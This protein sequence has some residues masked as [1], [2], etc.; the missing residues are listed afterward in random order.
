MHLTFPSRLA[1]IYDFP[2]WL[3]LVMWTVFCKVRFEAKEI[4]LYTLCEKRSAAEE[5]VEYGTMSMVV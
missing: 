2:P 4:V 5:T 1:Y 3:V